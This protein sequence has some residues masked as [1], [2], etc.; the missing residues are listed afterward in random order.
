MYRLT[1]SGAVD[2][3][4]QYLDTDDE[5][6]IRRSIAFLDTF[7]GDEITSFYDGPLDGHK[8]GRGFGGAEDPITGDVRFLLRKPEAFSLKT[9]TVL[10]GF[11]ARKDIVFVDRASFGRDDLDI[12]IAKKPKQFSKL[13]KKDVDLIVDRSTAKV[14]FN[15]NGS[16]PGLGEGGLVAGFDGEP[17]IGLNQFVVI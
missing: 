1:G 9:A 8:R 2:R 14:F 7:E 6:A 17:T 13:L 15:E 5:N 12:K 11:N 3:L 16:L 4:V 10:K